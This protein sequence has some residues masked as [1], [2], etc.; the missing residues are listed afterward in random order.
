MWVGIPFESWYLISI[1]CTHNTP[2]NHFQ[3]IIQLPLQ[4]GLRT[5]KDAIDEI[6]LEPLQEFSKITRGSTFWITTQT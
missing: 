6:K 2:L 3:K 4:F 1:N 5:L